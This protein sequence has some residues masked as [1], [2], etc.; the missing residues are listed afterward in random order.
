MDDMV[1]GVP[2]DDGYTY[3]ETVCLDLEGCYTVTVTG[4][5]SYGA[6][7]EA[8]FDVVSGDSELLSVSSTSLTSAYTF[9]TCVSGCGNPNAENYAPD[10]DIFDESLCEFAA[11]QGC[12]DEAACNFDSLAE[13]KRRRSYPEAGFDCAGNCLSGTAVTFNLADSYGDGWDYLGD[14]VELISADG[15]DDMVIGV[16]F[17]D[18]YTY[19]ETVCLDL[20]GC[21][22][23]TVTGD[24]SYGASHEA[25][26]DV[27]S[28]D[29]ITISIVYFIDFCLY[30]W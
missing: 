27:V 14:V 5:D 15:M 10:A 22:T 17:D 25:S 1:I 7:N 24:D 8:S 23:V 26:F 11:V 6:S 20:E 16:P 30:L 13:E 3:S 12:T 18:G 4:D 9:G 28:G 2:F 19:S 21:Y 29:R